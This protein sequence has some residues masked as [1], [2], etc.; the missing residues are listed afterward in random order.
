VALIRGAPHSANARRLIDY[1]LS[2][3]VEAA[4][5]RGD[6][7]QI[8][9]RAGVPAPPGTPTLV[10]TTGGAPPTGRPLLR[11]MTVDYPRL[12][13]EMQSVDEFLRGLFLR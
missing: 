8:P 13:T 1:L 5:A 6:S 10:S 2:R 4:L 11:A 9:L 7:R 3:E 12:A